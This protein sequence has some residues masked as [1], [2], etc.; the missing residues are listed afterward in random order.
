MLS[1]SI[2]IGNACWQLVH[3]ETFLVEI[4]GKQ[5]MEIVQLWTEDMIAA[6]VEYEILWL[7]LL[8]SH[9]IVG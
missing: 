9:T 7:E 5:L 3:W 6:M 2:K 4:L 8:R 1:G